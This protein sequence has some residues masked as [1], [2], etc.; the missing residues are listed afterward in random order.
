MPLS[1]VLRSGAPA[2]QRF[3]FPRG[4]D[5]AA[6][7]LLLAAFSVGSVAAGPAGPTIADTL[8]KWTPLLA[9]G[10]LLNVL[11]S[12]LAMALGTALGGFIGIGQLSQR[13]PVR[14]VSRGFTQLFRNTPWLVLLFYC[15]LLIPFQIR[16][17]GFTLALP[18]WLKATFGLSLAVMANVSELVRG[19]LQSIPAGQWDAA[20][21]LALRPNQIMRLVI[22]PQCVK[23]MLPPWMNLYAILVVSTP[24][25]SI[26]G[27]NE[28][29][30]LTADALNAEARHNLLIPMYLYVLG[31]FFLYCFP[32][33]RWTVALER[34]FAVEQ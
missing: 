16:L 10:F 24:L 28:V 25:C 22:L 1:P 15:M 27:V 8:A 23:R 32:I 20:R 33:A 18:D 12:V 13:T 21:S 29:M 5:A 31:W 6:I 9:R 34:R 17:G 19:A 7:I 11:I 3:A 14:I 26:V 4:A 2:V 30:T